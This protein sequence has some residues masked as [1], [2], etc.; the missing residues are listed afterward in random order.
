MPDPYCDTKN[1]LNRLV[2]LSDRSRCAALGLPETW[3]GTLGRIRANIPVSEEKEN[4]VRWRLGLA[5]LVRLIPVP[6]CEDCGS[7]HH[8]RCHGNAGEVVVLAENERVVCSV[9]LTVRRRRA[10]WRPMLPVELT[11]EQRA[12][13]RAFAQALLREADASPDCE[14]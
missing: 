10:A 5:P 6:P 13:V 9:C 4:E 3:R 7:V 1:A 12:Q 14:T 8:A 11:L 2:G